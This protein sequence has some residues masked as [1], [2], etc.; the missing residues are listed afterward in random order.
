[1]EDASDCALVQEPHTLAVG[2]VLILQGKAAPSITGTAVHPDVS[3]IP[4]EGPEHQ[5]LLHR[6]WNAREAL[7]NPLEWHSSG[8]QLGGDIQERA[9][10]VFPEQRVGVCVMFILEKGG[11]DAKTRSR[12]KKPDKDLPKTAEVPKVNFSEERCIVKVL[13]QTFV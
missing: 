11:V 13:L 4:G 9:G 6:L 10:V 8:H 1:M 3:L 12:F 7:L 5:P 2:G